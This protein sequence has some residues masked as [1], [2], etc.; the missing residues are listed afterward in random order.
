MAASD[1]LTR[2]AARAKKAE[3]R[4]AAAR[5]K[6]EAELQ[7]EVNEAQA[8]AQAQAAK[9][10]ETA[11]ADRSKLSAWWHDMQHTWEEHV[12]KIRDDIESRRAEHDADHAQRHADRAEDDAAFAVAFAYAAIEEAEYTVLD[13]QLARMKADQLTTA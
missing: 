11:D 3:D 13:A 6:A 5:S 1:D 7:A 9:L 12:G 2:L 8:S 10:R 4:A